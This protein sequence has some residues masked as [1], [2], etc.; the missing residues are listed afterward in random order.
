VSALKSKKPPKKRRFWRAL[1]GLSFLIVGLWL[2][3]MYFLSQDKT[4]TH[5]QIPVLTQTIPT[6]KP[7]QADTAWQAELAKLKKQIQAQDSSPW[8]AALLELQQQQ[9]QLSQNY[10][11]LY[12]QQR[13][14]GDKTDLFLAETGY[15][16]RVAQQRLYLEKDIFSAI[17]ALETAHQR[18]AYSDDPHLLPL[19]GAIIQDLHR[20]QAL[21]VADIQGIALSLLDYTRQALQL[22]LVQGVTQMLEQIDKS[23]QPNNTAK[24]WQNYLQDI[25]AK[26][27][28]LIVVRYN[29]NHQAAVLSPEQRFFVQQNLQLKLASARLLVLY[30]D[31]QGFQAALRDALDWLTDYY[32]QSDSGVQ[33]LQ[34][35]LRQWQ[36]RNL[37]PDTADLSYSLKQFK[38]LNALA[39]YSSQAPQALGRP[40]P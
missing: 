5:D 9:Q 35:Q 23:S 6:Q 3:K 37:M 15:L 18:L 36:Q 14:P 33:A 12:Q 25:L 34:Q 32:D 19:R 7:A 31:N 26:L 21:P 30:K 28:S 38:R 39:H 10:R 2:G 40:T 1:L 4:Q 13:H 29:A 24:T 27:K 22:P 8:Q 11:Y 16:L 17:K 20:L